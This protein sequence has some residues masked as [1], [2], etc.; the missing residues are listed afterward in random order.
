MVSSAQVSWS[1]RRARRAGGLLLPYGCLRL[2]R[3]LYCGILILYYVVMIL[4]YP[5]PRWHGLPDEVVGQA[6]SGCLYGSF[7]ARGKHGVG[8]AFAL[9]GAAVLF[10]A[11]LLPHK[12]AVGQTSC[13][14]L[15]RHLY[16]GILK[17]YYSVLILWYLLP[18]CHGRPDELVGQVVSCCP[19]AV[20]GLTGMCTAGY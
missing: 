1:A 17:L 3:P 8:Q 12:P 19:A 20:P 18:R 15:D 2:V 13:P 4:W 6:V 10:I 11:N 7:P 5:V 9:V 16:C 14:R